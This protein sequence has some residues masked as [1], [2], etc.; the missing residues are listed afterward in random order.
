MWAGTVGEAV[1][2]LADRVA[3][4]AGIGGAAGA[5][6]RARR[7][8]ADRVRAAC[9]GVA[10]LPDPVRRAVARQPAC[11][12]TFDQHPD[13]VRE[14]VA[15]FARL[16]RSATARCL[17]PACGPP[18]SPPPLAAAALR[19]AGSRDA[20]VIALRPHRRLRAD[21]RAAVWSVTPA[22][23]SASS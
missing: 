5:G 22:V 20:R 8:A 17:S 19:A 6:A 11:F 21:Q 1:A 3:G 2:L 14:L 23:A 13:D 15:R 7:A 10:R 18:A 16:R 9:D 12:R 4:G